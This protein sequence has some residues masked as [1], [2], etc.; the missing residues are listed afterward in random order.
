[1]ETFIYAVLCF[2][3]HLTVLHMFFLFL[4]CLKSV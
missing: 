4:K 3:S 1:M 2:D